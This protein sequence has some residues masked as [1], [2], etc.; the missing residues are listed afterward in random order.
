MPNCIFPLNI[1]VIAVTAAIIQGTFVVAD[2]V[3]IRAVETIADAA[4]FETF[5][6]HLVWKGRGHAGSLSVWRD[7]DLS[8]PQ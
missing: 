4:C 7:R 6:H 1:L 5:S 3:V 2:S 8:S